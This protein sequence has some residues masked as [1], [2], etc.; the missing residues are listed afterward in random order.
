MKSPKIRLID[1]SVGYISEIVIKHLSLDIQQGEF[2]GIF[3]PNGAGKTT[4]LCA[5]NKLSRIPEGKVLINNTE[6][7]VFNENTLRRK[8]GYV[9]QHF[10]VDPK[11]PITSEEVILM[12]IYGKIGLLHFTG[13]KEKH[14]IKHLADMFE[15]HHFLKKPFGQLSG[16]ERKKV[17]I[18]RAL[19]QEPEIM[20]MDEIFAWLDRNMTARFTQI[21]KE[22][23]IIHHLTTLIVSHD[24]GIIKQLCRRVI[25]MEQGKIIF[26]G[27]TDEFF[28]RM[29]KNDGIN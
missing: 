17:L 15:M 23:H 29:E 3:G 24:L 18:A 27:N 25:W 13:T 5:I 6:F 28:I 10:D 16:G 11:L 26:D 19:M 2:T 20:L 7:T 1:I 8:I 4:L 9:P 22:I 21:L 14:L 12:G